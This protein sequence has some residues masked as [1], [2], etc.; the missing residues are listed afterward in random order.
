MF[1][2]LPTL[3]LAASHMKDIQRDARERAARAAARRGRGPR[4]RRGAHR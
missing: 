4:L 3:D 1:T 2:G